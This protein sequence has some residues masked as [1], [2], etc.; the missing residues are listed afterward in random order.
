MLQGEWSPPAIV[1][2]C[3]IENRQVLEDLVYGNK[4]FEIQLQYHSSGFS[5][6][7]GY[8]CLYDLQNDMIDI[9]TFRY[10]LPPGTVRAWP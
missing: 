2:F 8:R 3:E 6:S 7:T 4:P 5:G 10:L 1:A 9:V